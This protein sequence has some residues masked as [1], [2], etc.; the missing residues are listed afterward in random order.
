M[1]GKVKNCKTLLVISLCWLVFACEPQQTRHRLNFHLLEPDKVNSHV[2]FFIYD[3]YLTDDSGQRKKFMLDGDLFPQEVALVNLS[4]QQQ[5]FLLLGEV[6]GENFTELEFTLGVPPTLNHSNPLLAE[7]PLDN[8]LMFWS[9]QQGYKFL[10]VDASVPNKTSLDVDASTQVAF[11]LGSTSCVSPSSLKPPAE[12]CAKDHRV[13]IRLENFDATRDVVEI[14]LN[15]LFEDLSVGENVNCSGLYAQ[16]ASC[17]GMLAKLGLDAE[18]GDC[19]DGCE[20]QNVFRV[21]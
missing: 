10:R 9:W 16:N 15:N 4:S 11:H 12:P 5:N 8:S 17:V 3:I 14:N 7:G 20:K 2:A 21:Q 1:L 6:D 18:T 13:K 19:E